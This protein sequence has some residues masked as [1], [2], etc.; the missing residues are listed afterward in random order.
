MSSF[1]VSDDTF[2]T[3]ICAGGAVI[4]YGSL[5]IDLPFQPNAA[6]ALAIVLGPPAVYAVWLL[7]RPK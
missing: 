5:A 6:A 7:V 3:P 1:P 4:K 2:A